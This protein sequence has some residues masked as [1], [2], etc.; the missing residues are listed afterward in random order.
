MC[1]M[2][3]LKT[4]NIFQWNT[5]YSPNQIFLKYKRVTN[6]QSSIMVGKKRPNPKHLNVVNIDKSNG[7]E[8]C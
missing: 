4:T 2:K 8:F 1:Y 6:K 5:N 7:E 3:T